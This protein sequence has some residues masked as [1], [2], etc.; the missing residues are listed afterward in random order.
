MKKLSLLLF[1]VLLL[2]ACSS[3]DDVPMG[4]CT[5]LY[6]GVKFTYRLENEAGEKCN[7]F[8]VGETIEMVFEIENLRNDTL[9]H[10]ELY[11][12]HPDFDR[13]YYGK[14]Y[15]LDGNEVYSAG[16]ARSHVAGVNKIPPHG[17]YKYRLGCAPHSE[18]DFLKPGEYYTV[19][20][21]DFHTCCGEMDIVLPRMKI[22]FTVE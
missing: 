1:P 3:R 20:A 2:A 4:E 8:K 9:C 11:V 10:T 17:S 16:W 19:Y 22:G 14:V 18:T 6:D 5:Y 7:T 21:G 15:D 13:N 12:H